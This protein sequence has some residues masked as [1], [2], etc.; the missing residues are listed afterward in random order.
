M[1]KIL[2][3]KDILKAPFVKEWMDL[4]YEMW[5][6]GWDER[7]GGNMSMILEEK[8][9]TPYLNVKQ[10]DCKIP[11]TFHVPELANHY[12]LVTG[13]G[14]YFR[15]MRTSPKECLGIVKVNEEGDGLYLLWGLTADQTPTSELPTHFMS[16]IARLKVDPNH[17]V[18]MHT[19]ATNLIAM[20]FTH[21]LDEKEFTKT[22]WRMCTE[23][24]VVF[25]DGVSLLPWMIPGTD[26][27]GEE[28]A[29]C[30]KKTRLVLWAHHGIFGVG[31]T[32][33]DAFGLIETAEKA[34]E[35][36]MRIQKHPGGMKQA[37]TDEQLLDLAKAFQVTPRSDIPLQNEQIGS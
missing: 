10:T 33:D 21:E 20:T 32:L 35:I 16:H 1:N 7:N 25:P 27:I 9:L 15:K 17:R 29:K 31:E 8:E 36:Y 22:L 34:A 4:S 24:I 12:F 3:Y 37:I 30:M 6:L 23:C 13:S 5:R 11:L 14:K 19:H 2:T 26:L 18:V 28:T